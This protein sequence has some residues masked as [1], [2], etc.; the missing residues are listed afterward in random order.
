LHSPNGQFGARPVPAR[1]RRN[2]PLTVPI[3]IS[4]TMMIA[5]TTLHCG[6]HWPV[7]SS[8]SLLSWKPWVDWRF[9]LME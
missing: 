7:S 5:A 3:M 4:I 6:F 2:M 9:E 1:E 8:N